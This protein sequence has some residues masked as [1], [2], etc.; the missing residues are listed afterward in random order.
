MYPGAAYWQTS[1]DAGVPKRVKRSLTICFSML[2]LML[3]GASLQQSGVSAV[4]WT[5]PTKA[6]EWNNT[7]AL[8]TLGGRLYTIEKSGALYRTDLT[9][10]KWVPLGNSDCSSFIIHHSSPA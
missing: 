9:N 2:V 3:A 6:G 7:I 5:H 1:Y 8:T 4:H 10:G